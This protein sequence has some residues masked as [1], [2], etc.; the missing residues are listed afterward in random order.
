MDLT[1][2]TASAIGV[3]L[4][5]SLSSE[6]W[7]AVISPSHKISPPTNRS[8]LIPAPPLITCKAPVEE[9]LEL[10]VARTTRLLL[11]STPSLISITPPGAVRIR[12]PEVA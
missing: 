9:L 7:N 10:A 3:I 6:V 4:S 8:F 11:I 2:F 5:F 1:L 12:S